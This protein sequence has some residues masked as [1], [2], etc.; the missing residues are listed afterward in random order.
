MIRA[1]KLAKLPEWHTPHTLRHSFGS[2]LI[3]GGVSPVYVQQQMGHA[4][5]SMTVDVYGS[6]LPKSDVGAL[7][8]IF[9]RTSA[10]E[11]GSKVVAEGV[12]DSRRT[13]SD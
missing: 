4:A 1:L 2:L 11:R 13:V 3:A 9:G 6:W 8:R 10:A 7:N 12:R 5:I